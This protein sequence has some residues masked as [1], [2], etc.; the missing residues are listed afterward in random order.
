MNALLLN[1]SNSIGA[2][3][4]FGRHVRDTPG[5]HRGHFTCDHDCTYLYIYICN[6]NRSL[7]VDIQRVAHRPQ[8]ACAVWYHVIYG[9]WYGWAY[10]SYEITWRHQVQNVATK[11]SISCPAVKCNHPEADLSAAWLFEVA[12]ISPRRSPLGLW[13]TA[14]LA[15]FVSQAKWKHGLWYGWAYESYELTWRHQV[16]SVQGEVNFDSERRQH[17]LTLYHKQNGN[18]DFDMAGHMK[19]MS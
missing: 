8:H 17:L 13:K 4:G 2:F 9:L 11:H 12:S 7:Q 10:E 15:Y 5:T 6:N 19:V 16:Q 1:A 3:V 14:T 18:M